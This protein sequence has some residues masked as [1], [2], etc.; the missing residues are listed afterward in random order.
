MLYGDNTSDTSGLTRVEKMEHTHTHTNAQQHTE[1][2]RLNF[3]Q[4]KSFVYVEH[5]NRIESRGDKVKATK[6]D[7]KRRGE[8]ERHKMK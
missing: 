7:D 6:V 2:V 8:I 3:V 1:F 4:R 5:A